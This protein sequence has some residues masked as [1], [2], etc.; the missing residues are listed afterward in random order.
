MITALDHLFDS[1]KLDNWLFWSDQIDYIV[2]IMGKDAAIS[3]KCS[4]RVPSSVVIDVVRSLI[5][6]HVEGCPVI[7]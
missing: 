6:S 4:V 5:L 3:R 2:S 1:T 7:W